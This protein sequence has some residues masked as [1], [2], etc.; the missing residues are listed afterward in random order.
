MRKIFTL[1]VFSIVV[2]ILSRAQ[3]VYVPL[4]DEY[5]HKVERYEIKSGRLSDKLWLTAGQ[6]RRQDVATFLEDISGDS[7]KMRLNRR[8][9]FNLGYLKDD[10]WEW[11]S[12]P[13]AGNS[14]YPIRKT[15]FKHFYRKKN[16]LYHYQAKNKIFEV[17]FNPVFYGSIGG[18]TGGAGGYT[19]QNTRGFELRGM[20]GRR[21]GFYTF[22]GEN[23]ARLPRYMQD[24]EQ[25]FGAVP[26]ENFYKD[27][28]TQGYDYFNFRG[29]LS[30]S[31]IKDVLQFQFGHD[32]NRLSPGYRSLILGNFA[33]GYLF[34]KTNVK[35]WIFN[36]QWM[37]AQGINNT[38]KYAYQGFDK[39]WFSMHHLSLNLGKHVNIG[40][41]EA[42]TNGSEKADA[43]FEWNYLNPIILY[44]AV[45]S[46]IGNKNAA[47][48][49]MDFKVNFLRHV[50]IY[51]QFAVS[52]FSIAEMRARSGWFGNQQAVQL[53]I[54]YVDVF[55]I[56]N[57]DIQFEGNY[58]RPFM[59]TDRI[60]EGA[61][62]HYNQPMAHPLGANF[63][64]VLGVVRYQPH[65]RVNL[66]AKGFYAV[67]G[68]DPAGNFNYGSDLTKPYVTRTQD[69]GNYVGTGA[70]TKIAMADF[71]AS[72]MVR[73]NLWIDFNAIY[74]RQSSTEAS[75]TRSNLWAALN[76]RM[77]IGRKETLF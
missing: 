33:P 43:R 28:K 60:S 12:D 72:Y 23:Q 63:W 19:F 16:A 1:S 11:S 9:K 7:A 34:L 73:H 61:Y 13:D 38:S 32:Q 70:N 64:E 77:N 29:Y 35:V 62:T 49:G 36:Y 47:I 58:V 4:D 15:F 46:F 6:I 54:K 31:A 71:C 27:F 40:I 65:R 25:K 22:L 37:L 3:G 67:Q 30:F 17:Q 10:N 69:Y 20:I 56:K 8:D 50:Q 39:K 2:S 45:E 21:L 66:T 57:L 52:E 68:L 42:I 74:R 75:L 5:Y 24:Y 51:G 41:F 44:R 53:G 18:S 59:Y 26:G 55:T 14:I 76:V 48:V